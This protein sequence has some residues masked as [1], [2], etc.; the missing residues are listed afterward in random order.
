M[1]TWA[2]I[3]GCALA[4][5]LPLAWRA[6]QRRFDP[7][8]PIVIFALAYGTMFVARPISMLVEDERRFWGVDVMPMLPR[9]L[10]LALLGAVAFVAGYELVASRTLAS[11][12]PGSRPISTRI[13][14]AGAL[15]LVAFALV[16]LSLILPL[17]DGVDSVRLLLEGRSPELGEVFEASS[18]YLLT[19]SFLFAPAAFVLIGLSL[20]DRSPYVVLAAALALTL[21]L[22]RLVPVG[23]RIVLL[24]LLGGVFVLVYVMRD[25]RPRLTVLTA[26]AVVAL[27]GSYLIVH[28]RDPTDDRTLGSAVEDLADRPHAVLDPVLRSGDAEMVLA[29]SAALTVIPDE[30]SYR[31]GGATVGNLVTRPVPRELWAGKP[32]PPEEEV[33]ATVWPQF[34]PGL[35]PAFSPLL[36][37]YWDLGLAGVALGMALVGVLARVFYDWFLLHRRAFG[38]QLIYSTGLWFMVIGARNDPVNTIVLA[39]FLLAPVVAIVLVASEGVLPVARTRRER[40]VAGRPRTPERSET[41]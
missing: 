20:R 6:R 32:L 12:L 34:Y 18:T 7:F 14:A 5:A 15:V 37:F 28:V 41:R 17:S 30:L 25:R 33:V 19:G 36:V 27:L 16:A 8:E 4:L 23:G 1:T 26:V 39:A 3:G 40:A 2:L 22:V 21:A 29:L 35:A 13:A 10:V 31:F 9:A 24:P 38:A 11:R